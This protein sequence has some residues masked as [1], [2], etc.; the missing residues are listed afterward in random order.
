MWSL[1]RR[2][3]LST[4]L[5]LGLGTVLLLLVLA[6]GVAIVWGSQAAKLTD[7]AER[8]QLVAGNAQ[9]WAALTGMQVDRTR[10]LV[11]HGS[12][13]ELRKDL[14]Q[15]I[16]QTR[17]EV[18]ALESQVTAAVD[19]ETRR[20]LLQRV[21]DL[22][23]AHIDAR[24]ATIKMIEEG[25]MPKVADFVRQHYEPAAR[26]YM[27]AQEEL[28]QS[29]QRDADRMR[30]RA[31]EVRQQAERVTLGAAGL[32]VLIGLAVAISLHRGI[33]P[34]AKLAVEVVQ[35][36][37]QRDFTRRFDA[38]GEDEIAQMMVSLGQMQEQVAHVLRR[39]QQAANAAG[40]ASAEITQG[41]LDLSAR[42]QQQAAAVEQTAATVQG[43]TQSLHHNA[44][45]A[46][47]V[48][49]MAQQAAQAAQS[50][51]A[52]VQDLVAAMQ[53]I[54]VSS[55]RIRDIIGTIDGLA[56]QTNILA[57]NAAV[58][59]ARAGEAGRGFAVVAGEVRSL[60]QRSAE[61]AREIRA[62]IEDNVQ[63]MQA[64]HERANS[65]QA[66]VADAV[67]R[68]DQVSHAMTEIDQ[69]SRDLAG[70]MQQVNEAVQQ[71]DT[72]TQR[73]AALVEEIG[74]ATKN[75]DDQVQALREQ[76]NRFK[77]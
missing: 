14:Q 17:A 5:A 10:T 13:A 43:M 56:F 54:Q 69:T 61:A 38:P 4:Q 36:M 51:G 18:D 16:A 74:A 1:L 23:K 3:R 57:L 55:Q 21:S 66:A 22:R 42:T 58:E 33:V 71:M 34:P 28:A 52:I 67:Q 73:N 12:D 49:A 35:T 77:V 39:I 48:R 44:E 68:I 63:R 32:A 37:A 47:R 20:A 72:V 25:D 76:I 62:I 41:N 27:Q 50:V 2:F 46:A 64:G 24:N 75:L 7:A 19:G 11:R 53:G 29:L 6:E 60:A 70:N 31:H 26:A 15:R 65:A 8:M 40:D 9:R 45:V 59:A 30:D